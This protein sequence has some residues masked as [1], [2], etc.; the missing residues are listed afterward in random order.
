MRGK[1]VITKI[2]KSQDKNEE[3]LVPIVKWCI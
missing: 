2:Y 1:N 3:I